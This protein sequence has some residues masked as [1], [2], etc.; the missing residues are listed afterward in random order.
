MRKFYF[1]SNEEATKVAEGQDFAFYIPERSTKK[2]AGYDFKSPI[3]VVVPAHDSMKIP[4]GI[5]AEMNETEALFL[6]PRSGMGFKYGIR[7]MN[8]VGIVDADYFN[9]PDNE[10]HIFIKLY[11]P[12]DNDIVINQ[13]DKF[14]QG[15]FLPFLT[16]DDEEEI[17]TERTSGMGSTGA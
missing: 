9:N 14:A 15:I 2:S 4:T 3:D 7:L 1:V 10:G 6:F 8:T 12:T 5:K 16:I 11:N 17:T 13:G